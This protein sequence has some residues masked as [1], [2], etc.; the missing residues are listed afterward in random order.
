MATVKRRLTPHRDL[1]DGPGL[2]YW[3]EWRVVVEVTQRGRTLYVT[4]PNGV[5]IKVTPNIAGK[6][7]RKQP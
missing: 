2:F 3:S 6:F 1:P 5:E 4:P 7:K